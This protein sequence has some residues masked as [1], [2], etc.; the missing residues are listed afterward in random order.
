MERK[1]PFEATDRRQWIK[2]VLRHATLGG[3]ALLVTYLVGRQ[4][5][6]GC[7][8]LTSRCGTCQLWS[9]C[10]LAPAR[11]ARETEQGKG[12]S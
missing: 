12:T 3:I 8:K 2:D 5:G 10:E 9:H 7:P 11:R 6:N 4:L 1:N